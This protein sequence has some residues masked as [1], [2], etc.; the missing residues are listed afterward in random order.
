M[1]E[2][3]ENV[4]EKI[5]NIRKKKPAIGKNKKPESTSRSQ[6]TTTLN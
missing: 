3:I 1:D 6:Q 5:L 2:A 4:F